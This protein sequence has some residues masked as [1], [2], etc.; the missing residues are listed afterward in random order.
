[1]AKFPDLPASFQVWPGNSNLP[2]RSHLRWGIWKVGN[3]CQG[4]K[5]PDSFQTGDQSRQAQTAG[6]CPA[7]KG[8][9][10]RGMV[11]P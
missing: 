7:W 3:L 1:M 11:A 8:L 5:V 2:D 10:A 4:V 9:P 6:A